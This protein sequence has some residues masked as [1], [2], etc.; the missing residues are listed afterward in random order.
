MTITGQEQVNKV[1]IFVGKFC[2]MIRSQIKFDEKWLSKHINILDGLPQDIKSQFGEMM[3]QEANN[4]NQYKLSNNIKKLIM[5]LQIVLNFNQYRDDNLPSDPAL[6]HRKLF[7]FFFFLHK[8]QQQQ[9][10]NIIN[11]IVEPIKNLFV[12]L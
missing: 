12:S 8:Q 9:I 3:I 5:N 4:Y 6:C 1:V 7:I 10:K 2:E 11:K